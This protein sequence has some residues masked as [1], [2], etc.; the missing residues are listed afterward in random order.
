[1]TLPWKTF[2]SEFFFSPVYAQDSVLNTAAHSTNVYNASQRVV[3]EMVIYY[4]NEY[5]TK[6][7]CKT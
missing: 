5:M 1:M 6:N 7:K 2:D 3:T 4:F